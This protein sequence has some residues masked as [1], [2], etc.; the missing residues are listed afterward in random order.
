MIAAF[1]AVASTSV[2][3]FAA[4]MKISASRPSGKRPMPTVPELTVDEL[5]DL[6]AAAVREA[7]ARNSEYPGRGSARARHCSPPGLATAGADPGYPYRPAGVGR[8]LCLAPDGRPPYPPFAQRLARSI[9][10]V[11]AGP[12][13][14]LQ[15]FTPFHVLTWLRRLFGR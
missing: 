1:L 10:G 15:V 5:E 3:L 2:P 4:W 13:L 11:A 9:V 14:L 8:T 6:V 12:T 7:L